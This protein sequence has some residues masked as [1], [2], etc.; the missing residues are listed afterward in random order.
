[1]LGLPTFLL[2]VFICIVPI[3]ESF[4][5]SFHQWS[6]YT[7]DMEYIGIKNYINILKDP[8][9]LKAAVNDFIIV[10]FK[11]IIICSLTIL[12]S[13]SLTRF[14]L[15]KPEK[16]FYRF[17]YY[18]PNILSII[19]ITNVWAF[20]L[21]PSIGLLNALLRILHLDFLIPNNGWVAEHTLP[22]IIF[23]A[24]W[25]AIGFYMI[26]LIAA[27]NNVPNELYESAQLDGAGQWNQLIYI[28][29]PAI[30]AQT[31]YMVV[32]I[33]YGSLAFNMNLVLPMTNGGPDNK[34]MVMGLYV[35]QY[36]LDGSSQ[37]GYANAAAICLMLISFAISFVFNRFLIRVVSN[38]P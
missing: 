31:R 9:F 27:I 11:G 33:I 16:M 30:S 24:S 1:M 5:V 32:S 21:D 23:I 29:L 37:V 8:I 19:V 3:L 10:F 25:C 15:R 20:F 22:V 4:I 28:T 18:I 17:V 7:L 35:Y 6:G 34:S 26:I 2:Y 12:F 38:S 13:I 36:G 14:R